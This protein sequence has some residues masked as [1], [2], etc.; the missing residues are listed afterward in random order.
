VILAEKKIPHGQALLFQRSFWAKRS[1]VV[2]KIHVWFSGPTVLVMG[3]LG[4]N[5]NVTFNVISVDCDFMKTGVTT[6]EQS[7]VN[8]KIAFIALP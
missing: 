7:I 2:I 3:L 8:L 4:D 5:I 1:F 6:I